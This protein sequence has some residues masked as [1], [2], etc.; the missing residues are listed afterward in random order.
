MGTVK[1][2]KHVLSPGTIAVDTVKNII[3]EGGVVKGCKATIKREF[4]ENN[5]LTSTLYKVG[6]QDGILEGKVEGYVEASNEYEKKLLSQADEFI[7]QLKDAQKERDEYEELLDA[8]E[9]EI[10]ALTEKT[11]LTEAENEL[12][13]ELLLKERQL[14]QLSMA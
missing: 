14:K 5:P 7:K 13:R 10:R 9:A 6:K 1:F 11:N 12:L 3:N 4:T 2:I 8:Y